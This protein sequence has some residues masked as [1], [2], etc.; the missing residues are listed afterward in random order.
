MPNRFDIFMTRLETKNA[1]ESAALSAMA[2]RPRAGRDE[3]NAKPAR[4]AQ[5]LAEKEYPKTR[6]QRDA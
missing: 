3:R 6:N 1:H 5:A 2:N 4:S